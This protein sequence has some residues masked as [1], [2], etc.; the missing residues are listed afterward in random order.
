MF[1][2]LTDSDKDHL[3]RT[4][5]SDGPGS[6]ARGRNTHMPSIMDVTTRGWGM[7]ARQGGASWPRAGRGHAPITAAAQSRGRQT[8]PVGC[9]W[10]LSALIR[11]NTIILSTWWPVSRH[12]EQWVS[13]ICFIVAVGLNIILL[14][15]PYNP[16]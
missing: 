16:Y 14:Q 10:K 11:H 8:G 1:Q 3:P 15:M 7:P 4:V 5:D 13:G 6:R 9:E 12:D 2:A